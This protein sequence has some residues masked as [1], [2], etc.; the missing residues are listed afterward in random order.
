MGWIAKHGQRW[1]VHN[2]AT[3]RVIVARGRRR[4]YVTKREARRIWHVLDC[5]YTGRYCPR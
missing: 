4:C 2:E 1:C 3:G 5:H